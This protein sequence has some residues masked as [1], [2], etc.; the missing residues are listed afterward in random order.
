MSREYDY[1][2]RGPAVVAA[3]KTEYAAVKSRCAD[4]FLLKEPGAGLTPD[5]GMQPSAI[6]IG[7][8]RES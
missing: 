7:F 2:K 6:S 1:Y 3:N 4:T 5:N 8:I